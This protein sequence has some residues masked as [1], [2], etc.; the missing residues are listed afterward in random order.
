M[1]STATSESDTCPG[2]MV[3]FDA[4]TGPNGQHGAVLEC[5][6][7]RHITVTGNWNEP[8]HAQTPIMRSLR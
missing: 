8:A 7:C 4:A 3:W 1:I 5:G 6:T 2:S